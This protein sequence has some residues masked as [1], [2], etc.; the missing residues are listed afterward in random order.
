MSCAENERFLATLPSSLL[1]TTTC[2]VLAE[3][4]P[5]N[6]LSPGMGQFSLYREYYGQFMYNAAWGKHCT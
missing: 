2:D 6:G 5:G 1:V 4:C 3:Q